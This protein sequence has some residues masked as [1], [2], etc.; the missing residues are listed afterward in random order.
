MTCAVCS[1]KFVD[2][3]SDYTICLR[4]KFYVAIINMNRLQLIGMI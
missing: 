4:K 1:I 3:P 2:R